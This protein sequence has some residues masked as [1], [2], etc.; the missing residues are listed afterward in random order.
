MVS[1][2]A[3]AM[4]AVGLLAATPQPPQWES[5]YG[6]ALEATRAGEKPLLVVLDKPAE[7]EGRMDSALLSEGAISGQPFEL[8]SHYELCHVDVTTKYGKKVADAF[9][10]SSFPYVAIIDKT[11]SVI[12]FSKT[13]KIAANEWQETLDVHQKGER[14]D[15]VA[16]SRGRTTHV[17]YKVGDE[18]VQFES[19]SQAYNGGSYC[20]SCQ[21]KAH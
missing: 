6:K 9:R 10:A 1:Y 13:G 4:I 14:S 18:Q 19:P 20:P 8:L 11:G 2:L 21:R 12:L 5:D 15:S 7:A 17:S 3:T 16:L